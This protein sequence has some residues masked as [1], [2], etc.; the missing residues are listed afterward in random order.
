MTDTAGGTRVCDD[1]CGC[2]VPCPG[3]LA[4]R[5]RTMETTTGGGDDHITC[6]CGQHCG[7]NPCTC[8]RSVVTT[9]VGKAYCK[10]GEGCTCVSCSS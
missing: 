6:S 3:G 9:G 2:P 5:C 8:A 4:C 1:T 7:C 10:C